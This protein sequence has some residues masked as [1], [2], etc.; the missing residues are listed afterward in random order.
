MSQDYYEV[1]AMSN[2]RLGWVKYHPE[3][4][5]K[6]ESI[7]T[8]AF[9]FG[10]MLHCRLLEPEKFNDRYAVEPEHTMTPDQKKIVDE[11]IVCMIA[12]TKFNMLETFYTY[13]K[14]SKAKDSV[15][16]A[17]TDLTT[18]TNII[19]DNIGYIQDGI[20]NQGKEI[21]KFEDLDTAMLMENGVRN[22]SY[23][24]PLI[25]PEPGDTIIS[26][27][28]T[29]TLAK[30]FQHFK[31]IN[32]YFDFTVFSEDVIRTI[33]SFGIPANMKLKSKIDSLIVDDEN[34]FVIF[35]D[36]KSTRMNLTKFDKSYIDYDY[37]RQMSFYSL[38]V[39]AWLIQNNF[40][41]CVS[42]VFP[43]L[44]PIEKKSP[45]RS[46]PAPI[47]REEL[48]VGRT[49]VIKLLGDYFWHEKNGLWEFPK[50]FYENKGIILKSEPELNENKPDFSLI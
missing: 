1:D 37:R 29:I 12:K 7:D 25:Y 47:S 17:D 6:L 18:V 27:E 26:G 20:D 49:E 21:I 2:S 8:D 15:K 9:K 10:R 38:A 11:Y 5:K 50:S 16:K 13:Y 39:Q 42:K 23:S 3:S 22:N 35:S 36:P 40:K 45:H 30:G 31:E 46:F 19:N 28:T 34:G 32:I 44:L 48:N 43:F 41:N 24:S 14:G 33:E 4:C